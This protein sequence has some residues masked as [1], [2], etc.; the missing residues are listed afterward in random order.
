MISSISSFENTN[1]IVP[2][3]KIFFWIDASA[4]EAAAA[5]PNDVKMLLANDRTT[6]FINGK[7]TVINSVRKLKNPSF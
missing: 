3:L 7:S 4:A 6:F 5:N 1:V 2:N